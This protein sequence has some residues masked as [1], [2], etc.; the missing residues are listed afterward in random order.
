MKHTLTQHSHLTAKPHHVVALPPDSTNPD[1]YETPGEKMFED[2]VYNKINFWANLAGSLAFTESA[3]WG[4]DKS[5]NIISQGIAKSAKVARKGITSAMK[6][7]IKN[8]DLAEN[9]GHTATSIVALGMVGHLLVFPIKFMENNKEKWVRRFDAHLDKKKGHTPSEEELKNREIAYK[10]IRETNPPT[11]KDLW[12]ARVAGQLVN[13][14]VVDAIPKA[15][16]PRSKRFKPGGDLKARSD[17]AKAADQ[18][19]P[20][21]FD[22]ELRV[23][24]ERITGWIG[25]KTAALFKHERIFIGKEKAAWWG[26]IIALE[27]LCTRITSGVLHGMVALTKKHKENKKAKAE[28]NTPASVST[29]NETTDRALSK[30]EAKQELAASEGKH[31][32]RFSSALAAGAVANQSPERAMT[33]EEIMASRKGNSQS[34][35]DHHKA[36]KLHA[37]AHIE[38]G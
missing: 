2:I 16:D 7:F 32:K 1:G 9:A 35:S 34:F 33:R 22:K 30:D 21:L 36:Q 18:K 11:W 24:Q 12:I 15:L 14:I 31:T 3:E 6:T 13:I 4:A 28:N 8:K 38:H 37:P 10:R 5:R 25:E 17:A 19:D 23:G 20:M 27:T 29:T 26:Y